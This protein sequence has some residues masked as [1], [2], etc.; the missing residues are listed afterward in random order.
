MNTTDIV[1]LVIGCFFV[2]IGLF[3]GFSGL[4]FTVLSVIGGFYC[5]LTFYTPLSELLARTFGI[6]SFAAS[7]VAMLVIFLAI[8]LT[9]AVLQKCCR[10]FLKETSLTWID[11]LFG[12]LA[13]AL[14]FYL[15]A[16]LM[17]VSGMYLSPVT[18]DRWIQESRVLIVTART[19]PLLYPALDRIGILPDLA[20]AQQDAEAFIL[21]QA[22]QNLFAPG[23]A[24]AAPQTNGD[25][26]TEAASSDLSEVRIVVPPQETPETAQNIQNTPTAVQEERNSMLRTFLSWGKD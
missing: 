8:T 3:K 19:W 7:A 4:V 25:A 26:R 16:L 14:I 17:L 22:S 12:G 13:G 2:I 24:S 21:K 11:K 20:Q 23:G 18:G 15:V 9:C 1:L 5:S 10:R 6:A